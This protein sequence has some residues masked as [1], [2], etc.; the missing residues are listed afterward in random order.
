M[1]RWQIFYLL[2][3]CL[4]PIQICFRGIVVIFHFVLWVFQRVTAY[5]CILQIAYTLYNRIQGNKCGMWIA[6]KCPKITN[7]QSYSQ[8]ESEKV[9]M[10]AK[11]SGKCTPFIFFFLAWPPFFF[12]FL[13]HFFWTE[14]FFKKI[15]IGQAK[16]KP[17][18]S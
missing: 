4:E 5:S 13:V 1:V 14:T 17:I 9:N 11:N 6:W 3:V 16:V 12:F 18:L 8:K 10:H 2:F 7:I 15:V